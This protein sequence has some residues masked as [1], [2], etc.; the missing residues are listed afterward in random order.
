MLTAKGFDDPFFTPDPPPPPV[1]SP[2]LKFPL[3][4]DK[5]ID[6][7]GGPSRKSLDLDDPANYKRDVEYDPEDNSFRIRE[8]VGDGDIRT[9]LFL[10]SEDYLKYRANQDE[11]DY[12]R[13]RLDALSMFNQKVKLPTLYKEG[14]FDRLFG[15][16]GISIKPQGNM[17]L[18][19]GGNWQNMEN[20][21]LTQRS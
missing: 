2:D 13:Q 7:S 16:Q 3:N 10:E 15:G 19:F 4:D 18:S 12:W 17:E 9:P 14:I 5:N 6:P 8:K 21:N 11:T 20:P 1:D